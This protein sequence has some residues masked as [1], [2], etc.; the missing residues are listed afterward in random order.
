MC[1]LN[2]NFAVGNFKI[3]REEKKWQ[4]C[5]RKLPGNDIMEMLNLAVQIKALHI[6]TGLS[7][8][9]TFVPGIPGIPSRPST[10]GKP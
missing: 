10:P 7:H 9:A 2:K 6:H 1:Y 3:E 4:R 5:L 8:T